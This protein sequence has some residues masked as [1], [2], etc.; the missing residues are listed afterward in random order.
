MNALPP[1]TG[2]VLPGW[3]V[4]AA[5]VVVAG[6]VAMFAAGLILQVWLVAPDGALRRN[7]FLAFWVAARMA[8]AG[9]AGAAYDPAHF[10]AAY[11][12]VGGTGFILPLGWH[13]PPS[14]LLLLAPLGLLP[15][16]PA[17]V[18][19]LVGTALLFT[20]AIGQVLRG[21]PGAGAVA[22]AFPAT[23][24]C[25]WE[26]QN[27]FLVAALFG[28]AL[29]RLETKPMLAGLFIGLLSVKPQF[30]VL[31]PL[32][33][34]VGGHWRCFAAATATVGAMV[35]LSAVWFGTSAWL[36]FFPSL[37]ASRDAYLGDFVPD[38]LQTVYG[39]I[40]RMIG[41]RSLAAAVHGAA[42]IGVAAVVVALW[43]RPASLEV[44]AAAAIAASF[45]VTPYAFP[46]D[47][48]AVTMGAAFLARAAL[49]RGALRA[50]AVL[51]AAACLMPAFGL[52]VRSGISGIMAYGLLLALALRRDAAERG[53]SPLPD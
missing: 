8:F 36:A 39:V 4:R 42:A 47:A 30:G 35:L 20:W 5:M 11:E 6:Y 31:L 48:V 28:A 3:A 29:A 2:P 34:A 52:V 53:L 33:L 46:Y 16:V 17:F 38:T 45:L 25:V 21:V 44:R 12:A 15:Y 26:G 41:S 19:W 7:D 49:D 1:S 14:F 51:L 27:A 22:L 18:A 23:F 10:M 24:L 9:D 40:A 50:E 43:R 13:N 37:A 32:L